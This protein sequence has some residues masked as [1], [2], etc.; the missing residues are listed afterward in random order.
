MRIS[1]VGWYFVQKSGSAVNRRLAGS[2]L[3]STSPQGN[4]N[5]TTGW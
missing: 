2:D 4:E 5:T 1:Q 3:L